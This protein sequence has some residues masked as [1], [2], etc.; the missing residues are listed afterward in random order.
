MM[1]DR[2]VTSRHYALLVH[3]SADLLLPDKPRLR[4]VLHEIFFF[5]AVA[6]GVSL[7][8]AAP[9]GRATWAAIVYAASLTALLGVSALYHRR[10]WRPRARVWMRRLDHSA[11][12][13]L[14]AGTYT[15]FC[16]AQPEGRALLLALVW[17]CAGLGVVKAMVWPFAPKWLSAALC[18]LM[19]WGGV[20][21]TP[22]VA[23]RGGASG[24]ALLLTGGLLYSA[25]AVIYALKRPNPVPGVFGYHEVFHALVVAAAFCHFVV[26]A[27]VVAGFGRL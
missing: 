14:I 7:V 12:F 22:T 18:L 15:P 24:L 2:S 1:H 10:S 4:G 25:G 26:V 19:G 16:A 6:A 5:V 11:I 23:A 27:I 9:A 3:S 8:L 17:G 13:V 21:L 20:A